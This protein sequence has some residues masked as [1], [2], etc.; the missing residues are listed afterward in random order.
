MDFGKCIEGSLG[1]LGV[2]VC[3]EL[4]INS[5]P[6]TKKRIPN[7]IGLAVFSGGQC[8]SPFSEHLH[9]NM[10]CLTCLAD[11]QVV[12][13]MLLVLVWGFSTLGCRVR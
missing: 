9:S 2:C 8:D 11:R 4:V 13:I 12:L 1:V 7:S 5:S 6:Q 10:S 3:I